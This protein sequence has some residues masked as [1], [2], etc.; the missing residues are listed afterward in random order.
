V[1]VQVFKGAQ[2]YSPANQATAPEPIPGVGDKS[3]LDSPDGQ[4]RMAGYVKGD[5]VVFVSVAF[6]NPS[7]DQLVGLTQDTL[8]NL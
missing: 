3:F 8:A 7:K 1:L 5:T 2:Y 6:A 4:P